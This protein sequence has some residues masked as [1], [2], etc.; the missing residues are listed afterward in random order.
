[1]IIP[2]PQTDFYHYALKINHHITNVLTVIVKL[3]VECFFK[4]S[5]RCN[6]KTCTHKLHHVCNINYASDT[7]REDVERLPTKK[8]CKVCLEKSA[9][10]IGVKKVK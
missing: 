7:Y 1:M 9:I 4:P 2:V 5:E 6:T 10:D 8:M 3:Q